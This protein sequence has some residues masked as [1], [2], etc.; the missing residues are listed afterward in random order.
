MANDGTALKPAIEFDERLKENVGLTFNVDIDFVKK[1]PTPDTDFLKDSLITEAIVSSVTSLDNTCSLPCAIEYSKNSGK[2][3][4]S[5]HDMFVEQ[6]K[7]LQV[8]ERCL[9]KST[10][11][12]HILGK[13]YEQCKSFCQTCY[14]GK[15]LCEECKSIGQVSHH[16]ALRACT[17][18]VDENEICV[19]RAVFVVTA[20]CETGNKGAFEMIRKS[21]EDETIDPDISI[22][23]VLPDCPHVGKSVKA[24]FSNWLKLN[25]ERSNIGL[26]RTLRNRSTSTT[27]K[28]M[29]KLILRNDHVKNKDRQDPTAVLT[30]CSDS[31]TTFLSSIGYVCHTI[32]PEL[33]KYTENNRF[34]MYPSP[35]SVSLAKFGWFL[36]LSWNSKLGQSTLYR[37]RLHSPVDKI[38]VVKKNLLFTTQVH[39]E[40]DVAF[41]SSPDGPL[42]VVELEK[43]SCFLDTEKI[44]SVKGW[45]TL[46][47]RYKLTMSGTLAN[48]RAEATKYLKSK[49]KQYKLKGHDQHQVKFEDLSV[50]A[51]IQSIWLVDRELVF[52][53]QGHTNK[54][55]S[56]QL[57]YDGYGV[58]A[59]A[60]QDVIDFEEGWGCI[61]SLCVSGNRLYIAHKDGITAMSI[62][63]NVCQVIYQS[64]DPKCTVVPFQRGALFSDQ[65]TAQIYKID[66]DNS[67][68]VFAGKDVEGC[69]DGPVKECQFKQPM[70]ICVEFDNVVYVCDAQSNSIKLLTPLSQTA[71]FLSALG[72]LYG[73]FSVH[74]KGHPVTR[75]TLSE[76]IA[77]V[78]ECKDVLLQYESSVRTIEGLSRATLNGPQ[79]MVSAAT[80]KSID[81]LHWGLCRMKT[82][83]SS[84]S[85]GSTDLL[86]C[87][88]LDVE[89]LHST[90]HI[91]H[92]LLSKKEYCRDLGNTIKES[93]KRLSST[94]FTSF[95]TPARIVVGIQIQNMIFLWGISRS[96]HLFPV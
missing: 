34:G 64:N 26:L 37:A 43:N 80:M 6:V 57:S 9:K 77:K 79:G 47:E 46:K 86:S 3:A 89:H 33:D 94:S 93:T 38:S 8:C 84:V 61:Y 5:C 63:S 40:S 18:C 30:L 65:V 48:I 51:H 36:F 75:R 88:T 29:R 24:S 7:I 68:H 44:K 96:Y 83:L 52:I 73:A 71:K 10:S 58:C 20:D 1:N 31:L 60:V 22:L 17:S 2:T 25:N 72:K 15:E 92:P 55:L 39:Y 62:E 90:S 23:T 16:P 82:M 32:V 56:A 4:D 91:K 41:L 78:G 74:K 28:M 76:A 70:G 19:K 81:M 45:K 14:N 95:I 69:Q 42:L 49:E 54:I 11:K 53:A 59:T 21:I 27:M 66:E 13:C 50:Q 87:M 67:V 12:K 85:F 35:I